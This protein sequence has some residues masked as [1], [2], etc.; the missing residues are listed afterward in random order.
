MLDTFKEAL[1]EKLA[2]TSCELIDETYQHRKH[3]GFTE[4]KFHIAVLIR[5]PLFEGKSLLQRHRMIYEALDPWM[6]S[7]LHAVKIVQAEV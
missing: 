4:G 1:T 2:A 5:S 6:K 7:H 3:A